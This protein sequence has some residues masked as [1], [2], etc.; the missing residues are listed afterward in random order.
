MNEWEPPPLCDE[1]YRDL[2]AKDIEHGE[3]GFGHQGR[4]CICYEKRMRGVVCLIC[5]ESKRCCCNDTLPANLGRE[6]SDT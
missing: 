4:C 2:N 1:C 5:N 6:K 3:E